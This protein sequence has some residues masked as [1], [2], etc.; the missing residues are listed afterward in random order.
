MSGLKGGIVANLVVSDAAPTAAAD[1]DYQ[2][3]RQDPVAA[4]RSGLGFD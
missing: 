1:F 2:P 3:T 4:T